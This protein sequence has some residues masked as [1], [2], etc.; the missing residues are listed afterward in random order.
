MTVKQSFIT[1]SWLACLLL[2]LNTMKLYAQDQ[3]LLLKE[4][5]N[6]QL[7]REYIY[8]P[9][10]L[11][12]EEKSKSIY[13]KYTYDDQGLLIK[14]EVYID[15]GLY[16]SSSELVRSFQMREKW[17]SPEIFDVSQSTSYRYDQTGKLKRAS[18][19]LGTTTYTYDGNQITMATHR[20]EGEISNQI[21][22]RYDKRGN[23]IRRT[24]YHGVK[25]K[26]VDPMQQTRFK[27]DKK[28]NPFQWRC[29]SP[30]PGIYTNPNNVTMIQ[31]TL[32][33]E[34]NGNETQTNTISY[35]YEY[36][37]QGYPTVKNQHTSYI[38]DE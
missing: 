28:A 37:D 33:M 9:Q 26:G 16:S 2:S 25:A 20:H 21:E 38:Y 22:F 6:N 27:Y 15:P 18:N 36:N 10:G 7:V 31:S 23:L 8:N 1:V 34:A 24:L 14:K 29:A 3:P 30:E 13:T 19:H 32:F 12:V 4:F 35:S 17:A 11:L 5:I